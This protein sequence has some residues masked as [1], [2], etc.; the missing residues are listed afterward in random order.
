MPKKTDSA[1]KLSKTKAPKPAKAK[2]LARKPNV[3][4]LGEGK[5]DGRPT[6]YK[7]EYD[8]QARKMCLLGATDTQLAD[9]FEVAESSIHLW[10]QAHP[11]FSE[12]I[13]A[14]KDIA[15]AEIAASL[16]HRAKGYSHPEDD[17]RTVSAGAN[18]GSEIVIT[19]TIKHYP[20]DTAAAIHW[21]NN[22]QKA[23]WRSKT[24]VDLNAEVVTLTE[25]QRKARVLELQA[26]LALP[27]K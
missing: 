12:S 7:P 13:R 2:V 4:N 18:M 21:L 6:S 9:F 23:N 26:K 20:P 11:S 22:R 17:I 19:P 16:F 24:E 14:G 10:K 1:E 25:D 3:K 5:I 27:T 8:E 15:D